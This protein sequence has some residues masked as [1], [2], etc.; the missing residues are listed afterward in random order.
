MPVLNLHI[1]ILTEPDIPVLDMIN[2]MNQIYEAANIHVYVLSYEQALLNEDEFESLNDL[3]TESCMMGYPSTE[4]IQLA[5]IEVTELGS[6]DIKVFFCR[7][8]SSFSLHDRIVGSV[9][10]CASHPP[11][12][13]AVYISSISSKYTLAHEIGHVLGLQHTLTRGDYSFLMTG[14]GTA[15]ISRH[16]PLL[17]EDEITT[18]LGSNFFNEAN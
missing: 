2:A 18:I 13:P 14:E 12:N 16:P 8:V 15:N 10:G 1:R 17:T 7:T 6:K 3:D 5:G 11:N 4:Q 9:N